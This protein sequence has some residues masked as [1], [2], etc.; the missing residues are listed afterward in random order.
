MLR[1]LALVLLC[2]LGLLAQVTVVML[3]HAEKASSR[4]NAEL[5][6]AGRLRAQ[7]LVPELAAFVPV[8]L[9]ASDL[10]RTQQTLEPLSQRLNLPLRIRERSNPR[11][12]ATEILSEFKEGTVVVCGHS[13]TLSGIARAL[14]YPGWI[15]EPSGF[16]DL[17][18]LRLGP[19]GFQALEVRQQ[20]ARSH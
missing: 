6:P 20:E 3:R 18:I 19:D 11:G 13:D 10:R 8:A 2:H 5:S 15:S 7:G 1:A 9:F 12:L 4:L 17:W 16:D 14:G